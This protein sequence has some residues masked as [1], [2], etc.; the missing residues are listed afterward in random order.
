MSRKTELYALLP[1]GR[2]DVEIRATRLIEEICHLEEQLDELKKLPFIQI[3]P[4]NNA[5]QKS[6]PAA[7][8]YKEFLQQYNNCLKTLNA[9]LGYSEENGESPL[10]E[11]VK[12]YGGK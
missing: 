4:N 9:M 11:W 5:L 8:L 3:H 10:R 6:T 7:K 1:K 12:S 2:Q